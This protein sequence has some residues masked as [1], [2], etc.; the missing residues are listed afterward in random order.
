MD[1]ALPLE[2]SYDEESTKNLLKSLEMLLKDCKNSLA[3]NHIYPNLKSRFFEFLRE[4][5]KNPLKIKVNN[6]TNGK[7]EIFFLKGKDIITLFTSFSTNDVVNLPFE[8]DKILHNDFSALKQQLSNLF[9]KPNNGAGKGMRL[10]VWCA[11][12][13]PFNSQKVIQEETYKYPEVKGL[14]P[15]T[16]KENICRIWGVKKVNDIENKSISTSIPILLINGEYDE[17]TPAKWANRMLPNFTNSFH[18]IFKGWK[19]TPT[20]NWSNQCAMQVAN[21][22]FNSPGKK[23]SSDCFK[24]INKPNF[25]LK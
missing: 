12:E 16:F 9:N 22:F 7:K 11:E 25:K 6:P 2:V 13:Y 18:F 5:T 24:K 14:S 21:D 8:I 4:K 17:I 20:T 3:C 1:S 19:H 10:S 15:A 23:P